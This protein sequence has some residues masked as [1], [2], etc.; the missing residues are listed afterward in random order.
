MGGGHEILEIILCGDGG[1]AAE[2]GKPCGAN[3]R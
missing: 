1:G 3:I 2:P